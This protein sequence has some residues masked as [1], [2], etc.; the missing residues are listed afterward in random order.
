MGLGDYANKKKL[1]NKDYAKK[2][3]GLKKRL[4][5]IGA[6][7]YGIGFLAGTYLA[8]SPTPEQTE[9]YE[10]LE[11]N[12]S[13]WIQCSTSPKNLNYAWE[14][15]GRLVDFR[16]YCSAVQEKNNLENPN[17]LIDYKP[18]SLPDVNGDGSVACG[19]K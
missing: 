6:A 3:L 12:S 9:I 11:K 17:E 8:F 5:Q 4:L 10:S 7:V 15:E 2:P 13:S 14:R 18:I 1:L 19:E 16:E